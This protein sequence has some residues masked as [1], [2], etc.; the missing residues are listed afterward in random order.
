[1]RDDF[2]GFTVYVHHKPKRSPVEG[3]AGAISAQQRAGQTADYGKAQGTLD[4]FEGPIKDSP[5]YKS[6]L[7][8]STDATSGAYENAKASSAS[9]AKMAGFG[10]SQPAAQGGQTE[11]EAKEAGDLARLPAEAYSATA[12]KSLE[13][14]RQTAGMG[15]ELGREGAQYFGDKVDLEKEYQARRAAFSNRLWKM[16][17][18]AVGGVLGGPMGA[19]AMGGA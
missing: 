19:A 17:G 13:A 7:A 14:A 10:Y 12:D 9:R 15:T 3:E 8:T 11:M 1:M 5:Y 6:L 4:Q 16:G 18:M 2:L